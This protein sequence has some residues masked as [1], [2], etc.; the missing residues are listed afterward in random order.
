MTQPEGLGQL[1][2][3]PPDPCVSAL[4]ADRML[5]TLTP[6]A[7]PRAEGCQSFGLKKTRKSLLGGRICQAMVLFNSVYMSST[8]FSAAQREARE[9]TNSLGA[10]FGGH[11][12]RI[13][14]NTCSSVPPASSIS[15]TESYTAFLV[16]ASVSW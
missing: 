13:T 7:L 6:W 1:A 14:A 4:Q 8:N 15:C 10:D 3:I 5:G 12:T 2:A 16:A 9:Q 11:N